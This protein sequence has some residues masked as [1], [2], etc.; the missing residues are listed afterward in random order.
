MKPHPPG[1]PTLARLIELEVGEE[2]RSF[3]L[4]DAEAGRSHPTNLQLGPPP[5]TRL[6]HGPPRRAIRAA[7]DFP[8]R[9]IGKNVSCRPPTLFPG[10]ALVLAPLIASHQPLHRLYVRR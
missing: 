3:S 9:G 7:P 5:E 8:L 2:R 4:E 1:F 6:H 10:V